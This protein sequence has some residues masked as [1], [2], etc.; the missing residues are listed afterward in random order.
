LDDDK[1]GDL[2]EIVARA[3]AN[4]VGGILSVGASVNEWDKVLE[5]AGA[6]QNVWASLGVHPYF[7]EEVKNIKKSAF[8][9]KKVI[10]IGECGLDYNG[11]NRDDK[12]GQKVAFV[13]QLN[14]AREF[15]LPVVIHSREADDDMKDI[16]I[17]EFKNKE[18]KAV[19]HSYTSG[20]DL[21][22]AGLDLGFYVSA[23]GIVTFKNAQLVRENFIKAPLTSMLVETDGPWLAPDPYRGKICEP[24]MVAFTAQKLA[25]MKGVSFEEVEEVTAKNFFSLFQKAVLN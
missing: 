13:E 5:I 15:D 17:S 16:L 19:L 22:K 18:F 1:F 8:E 21:L 23:S 4:G 12:K 9:S 6:Y 2:D 10:A 7:P 3:L 20:W 25:Q 14:I 24:F 11:D